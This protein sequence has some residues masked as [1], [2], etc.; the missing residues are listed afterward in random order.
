[1]KPLINRQRGS[2]HDLI[3]L[4][5]WQGKDFTVHKTSNTTRVDIL[6][7][8]GKPEQQYFFSIEEFGMKY[9]HQVKKIREEVAKN[10]HKIKHLKTADQLL[11]IKYHAFA[12]RL[13]MKHE[14]I[15]F[16]HYA[17]VSEADISKAYY[18]TAKNL[19]LISEEFYNECLNLPK[20]E[21]L[22]LLGTIATQKFIT[23][24]KGGKR[25]SVEVKT[26]KELRRAWF[27]ICDHIAEVMSE[28]AE[29]MGPS[30]LFYW[31]DGIYF[32]DTPQARRIIRQAGQ[33]YGYEWKFNQVE[34]MNMLNKEGVVEIMLIK[35]G[36]KKVFYPPANKIYKYF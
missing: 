32:T 27:I 7:D 28:I 31:V 18:Q 25:K 36:E 26:D 13:R 3:D 10:V 29:K 19:G 16:R 21:R 23:E 11:E 14:G 24:Y 34:E 9:L 12:D 8:H 2:G 15:G 1:M 33:K 35:E 30:F 6:G 5:I 22:R 17:N 4:L 20:T